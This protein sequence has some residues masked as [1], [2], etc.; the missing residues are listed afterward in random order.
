MK[1]SLYVLSQH[2]AD[3]LGLPVLF[4]L[5]SICVLFLWEGSICYCGYSYFGIFF[6]TDNDRHVNL[7][8]E[9]QEEEEEEA[10][11]KVSEMYR[12]RCPILIPVSSDYTQAL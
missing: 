8:N 7:V 6:F 4:L 2:Q 9:Q 10:E 3:Y 1:I 5:L 11:G 12:D